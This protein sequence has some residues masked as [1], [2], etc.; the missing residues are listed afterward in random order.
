MSGTD[1]IRVLH[2]DDDPAVVETVAAML[3]REDDRIEVDTETRPAEALEVL[4][5]RRVDCVISDY[6]MPALDGVALLESVRE[7]H[8]DLPFVLYT[9]KGS[10]EVAGEA[11][12]A[13]ATDYLQKGRGT[14]Q[15]ALLATRVVTAVERYRARRRADR[16]ERIT[17]LLRRLN[18][19]LVAAD[20]VADVERT[21]CETLA[22]SG[23]Y[24][25][26][27]TGEPDGEGRLVPRASAGEAG[28]YLAEVEVRYDDSPR[29]QGP[30]GR[31]A[32]TRD[33][34]VSQPIQEVSEVDRWRELTDEYGFASVAVL[35][36]E[37]DGDLHGVL[38]IYAADPYAFGETERE[39]LAE[40]AETVSDAIGSARARSRL[41]R[42]EATL[43][44]LHDIATDIGSYD[45]P[46][47]VC[48]RTIEAAR[49][50]LEFDR[51]VISLEEDG[52]LPAVARSE[53]LPSDG[54]TTMTVEEGLTGLTYRTGDSF[55]VDDVREHPAAD[56]QGPYRA[57]VSVPV[58]DHGVFQ[59]V[60]E[61]VGAFD[62]GDLELAETLVAHAATALDRLERERDLRRQNERLEEFASIVS[63]DLRN[64]LNVATSRLELAAA[65]CDSDHLDA[66]AD[67]HDRIDRLV[68]DLLELARGSGRA[69]D[70]EPV[71]LAGTAED[72]W[73][74]AA[75]P[76]ATLSVAADAR[77]LADP[78]RLHQLVGN[79]LANAVEHGATDG[80]VTVTVGDH[81]DGFYVAD[82]GPGVPPDERESVFEAGY[83]TAEG[84]TGFGL[85]IVRR[86]AEAHGWTVRV[87]DSAAGGARFE[88]TGVEFADDREGR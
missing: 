31:A 61:T 41:E 76:G 42:R 10:E 24:R 30:G 78:E 88:I 55:L 1:R 21:V 16:Q 83:S 51:S 69:I 59:A 58:G 71:S 18:R 46:A 57:A 12:R 17:D 7:T 65:D 22:D 84:G 5:E 38:P 6:D 56:P 34:Q 36:L 28:S 82:D 50:V 60:T 68:G 15:Y 23:A 74:A 77:V 63:H 85:R 67:A 75:A 19:Q 39:V 86:V 27:W 26:A 2:V 62:E 37:V 43:A 64:P 29:G 8:P 44:T 81:Q 73:A 52:T 11:L 66:V 3:E 20:S 33:L 9:G 72:C 32:R 47:A 35:P 13:G 48:E 14:E 4:G 49:T 87:V 54:T 45:D 79:L 80:S 70:R 25:F 53:D 40:L